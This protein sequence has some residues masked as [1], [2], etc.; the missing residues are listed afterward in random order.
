MWFHYTGPIKSVEPYIRWTTFPDR[1]NEVMSECMRYCVSLHWI[2]HF[3][4]HYVWLNMWQ[5]RIHKPN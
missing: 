1:E 3:I 5:L 2:I 4:I